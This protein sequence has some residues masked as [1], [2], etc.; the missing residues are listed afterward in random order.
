[1]IF[2]YGQLSTIC[3]PKVVTSAEQSFIFCFNF[4]AV[5]IVLVFVLAVGS[6]KEL[7][8]IDMYRSLLL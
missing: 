8:C 3:H 5:A 2:V 1:M 4:L 7:V 6:T